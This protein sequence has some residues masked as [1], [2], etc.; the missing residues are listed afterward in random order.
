M[1]N[2]MQNVFGNLTLTDEE[3]AKLAADAEAFKD[4]LASAPLS[5]IKLSAGN[6]YF[7]IPEVG[8]VQE[9][10]CVIVDSKWQN[11][12]Y[13]HPYND[14]DIIAPGCFAVGDS[15]KTMLADMNAPKPTL[16]PD[17]GMAMVCAE[18]PHNQF[19]TSANGKGK[20]CR[21]SR[22]LAL[23]DCDDLSG[24]LYFLSVPPASLQGFDTYV[25]Q[26][27]NQRIPP[28]LVKTIISLDKKQRYAK[29]L[30]KSEGVLDL[31]QYELIKARRL[32]CADRLTQAP[33]YSNYPQGK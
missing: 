16:N 17:T 31:A 13:D 28:S 29:L 14:K 1:S 24:Q 9:L 10:C 12:R 3:I 21:N 20:L 25:R 6:Q 33:D 26:L 32:E 8:N 4:K 7:E 30:F 5:R 19:G 15:D 22:L 27:V 11:A 23:V 18:C 2:E